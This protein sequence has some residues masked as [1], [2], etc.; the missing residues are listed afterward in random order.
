VNCIIVIISHPE[1]NK[2]IKWEKKQ[3]QLYCLFNVYMEKERLNLNNKILLRFSGTEKEKH[4]SFER[5][6]F[7]SNAPIF[8]VRGFPSAKSNRDRYVLIG[9]AMKNN[10]WCDED[11]KGNEEE[12]LLTS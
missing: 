3:E 6:S 4:I 7:Y 11:A 8:H 1:P 9:A 10:D 12:F 5:E 2:I